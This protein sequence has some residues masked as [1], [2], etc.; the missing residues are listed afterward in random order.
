MRCIPPSM[1]AFVVVAVSLGTRL[2]LRLSLV[3]PALLWVSVRA[4]RRV[5]PRVVRL[6]DPVPLARR[7]LSWGVVASGIAVTIAVLT[8]G[9]GKASAKPGTQ[10]ST[11]G[12]DRSLMDGERNTGKAGIPS[13]VSVIPFEMPSSS[14]AGGERRPLEAG[15]TPP[16]HSRFF[17]PLLIFTEQPLSSV[18]AYPLREPSGVV[19]EIKGI[20]EPLLSSERLVGRDERVLGVKRRSTGSV[21][22]YIVYLSTPV[23]KIVTEH[24]GNVVMVYPV[25]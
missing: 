24:E 15:Q 19:I 21:V 17:D 16:R 11:P 23:Q 18:Y 10:S 12:A 6:R 4:I 22:R 9:E 13:V 25:E 1:V 14:P 5:D 8:A 20:P 3:W 2:W 7:L